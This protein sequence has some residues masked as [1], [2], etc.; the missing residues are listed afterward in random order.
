MYKKL[1]NIRSAPV[2]LL[3]ASIVIVSGCGAKSDGDCSAVT[4]VYE[5]QGI[6]RA[7]LALNTDPF[8]GLAFIDTEI[9][10]RY[11]E[12]ILHVLFSETLTSISSN[13]ID[14]LSYFVSPA[15]ACTTSSD[16]VHF[17]TVEDIS[18]YS[19]SNYD[20]THLAGKNLADLLIVSTSNV[21]NGDGAQFTTNI[22]LSEYVDSLPT[23]SSV[24]NFRFKSPPNSDYKHNIRIEVTLS[25][26]QSFTSEPIQVT[27]TP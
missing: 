11:D 21:P 18:V 2:T 9:A 16:R 20:D 6:D 13:K 19:S 24:Y 1:R 10:A 4:S 17:Q 7:R 8:S 23:V 25:D 12:L 14:I 22:D 15:S 27:I 26:G 3:L 5:V